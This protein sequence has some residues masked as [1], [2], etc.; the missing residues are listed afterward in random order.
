MKDIRV[1]FPAPRQVASEEV[2]VGEPGPG[3]VLRTEKT[4]ISTGT[5]LTGLSGEF[6]PGSAWARYVRCPWYPGYSN[7]ARVAAAGL[8]K[9]GEFIPNRYLATDGPAAYGML[10]ED[11]TRTV[12]VILDWANISLM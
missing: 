11:R 12:G 6:P 10:L 3:Q 5:E 4:L 8:V 7:V 9:V 1:V 2:E